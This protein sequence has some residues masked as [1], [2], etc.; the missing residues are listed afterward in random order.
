MLKYVDILFFVTIRR[1]KHMGQ[2]EYLALSSLTFLVLITIAIPGFGAK[3]EPFPA[4][5]RNWEK[6]SEERKFSFISPRGLKIAGYLFD[7]RTAKKFYWLD[8][9]EEREKAIDKLRALQVKWPRSTYLQVFVKPRSDSVTF[10]PGDFYL[11]QDGE[12]HGVSYPFEIEDFEGDF[13]PGQLDEETKA[14][15]VIPEEIDPDR[16][17]EFWYGERKA[18]LRIEELG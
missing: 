14:F 8:W 15:L 17:F 11:T 16:E 12:R 10:N 4:E 5:S 18:V 1:D 13:E 2:S 3:E 7:R 9:Y 6:L